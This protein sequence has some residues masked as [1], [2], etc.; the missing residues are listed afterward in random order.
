MLKNKAEVAGKPTVE[1]LV[2]LTVLLLKMYWILKMR[3]EKVNFL[4]IQ[5]KVFVAL[6]S[7]K[8]WMHLP[9]IVVYLFV[10]IHN[11]LI[12]DS[13]TRNNRNLGNFTCTVQYPGIYFSHT[14]WIFG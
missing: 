4:L 14:G 12:P 10:Y 3:A 7:N 6:Y 1:M 8:M 13:L 2:A 11:E 5:P 9:L